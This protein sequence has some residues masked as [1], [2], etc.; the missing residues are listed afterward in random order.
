MDPHSKSY[1]PTIG[2]PTNNNNTQEEIPRRKFFF[3]KSNEKSN[4]NNIEI[5]EKKQIKIKRNDQPKIKEVVNKNKNVER[6]KITIQK[7]GEEKK[8]I[9]N[10]KNFEDDNNEMTEIIENISE[11]YKSNDNLNNNNNE[12]KKVVVERK[13]IF[14]EPRINKNMDLKKHSELSQDI[15]KKLN[16]LSYNCMICFERVNRKE[17]IWHCIYCYR[18]FHLN[19]TKKWEQSCK[20]EEVSQDVWS[21]PHCRSIFSDPPS[22]LCYCGKEKKPQYN[23]YSIVGSCNNLCGK[24]RKGECPHTCQ[25]SC[26]PGSCPSCDEIQ[27]K[28]C[29]CGKTKYSIG[30]SEMDDGRS[31]GE[32]CAK[33]LNCGVHYCE[34]LCHM[35]DCGNCTEIELQVCYCGETEQEKTCGTGELD[36]SSGEERYFSCA[37]IC[38]QVLSCGKHKCERI[39]HK[40]EP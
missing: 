32:K 25:N 13:K 17:Q 8:I 28:K 10:N 4:T 14:I 20:S 38:N 37:A 5:K 22:F 2:N 12:E 11:L 30:C 36:E 29:F 1:V 18:I 7:R 21:C 15:I 35:G 19:C 26:H 9:E 40:G 34:R 27:F 6:K 3:P 23:T 33:L 24:K 16:N 31:C 39:C